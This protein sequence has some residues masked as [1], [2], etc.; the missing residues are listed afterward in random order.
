MERMRKDAVVAVVA[1]IVILLEGLMETKE[2]IC[3]NR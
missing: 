2:N 1:I 3:Q